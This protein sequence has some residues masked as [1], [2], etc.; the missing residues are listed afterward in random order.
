MVFTPIS[1]IKQ[2]C[3]R[4]HF[5]MET[6]DEEPGRTMGT[7]TEFPF[8]MVFT[9]GSRVDIG[10][11]VKESAQ[12]VQNTGMPAPATRRTVFSEHPSLHPCPARRTGHGWILPHARRPRGAYR[13]ASAHS[14]SAFVYSCSRQRSHLARRYAVR[15]ASLRS[16][17]RSTLDPSTRPSA[18]AS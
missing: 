7:I 15:A 17:A 8:I 6:E 5:H 2:N 3:R 1:A 12:P 13:P 11:D 4:F 10:N 16:V 9:A 18:Y 14:S